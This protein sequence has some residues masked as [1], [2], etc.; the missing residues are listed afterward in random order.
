MNNNIIKLGPV[1]LDARDY[2]SQGNAILGIRDSG[3][4]YTATML[5]ERLMLAGV[6]IIAFDPIGLWRHLKSG[7]GGKEGF[8]VVVAGGEGA[9]LPLT[10]A[11]APEIVRAAMREGVSLVIDL[12][13]M[14]LSK[15]DWKRIVMSCVRVLLYENKG[16][17]LRHI[18][19]EEA[20]EFAPQRVGPDQ[21][22]VYA[23]MEKLARMGGNALLGYTL[24][25]QR[26]EEVNK[27]VLELCDG[28]FLH[29]QKG[30]NSLTALGK[31][32]DM[33][34]E[35]GGKEIIAGL[36]MLAQ[37][38]CWLWAAGTDKP[39]LIQMPAKR[40]FHPDRR[41]TRDKGAVAAK[42]S[43]TDVS[44]FVGRM[45][46]TLEKIIE[47]ARADDPKQLKAQIAKL[48]KATPTAT[49]ADLQR[50][51]ERGKSDAQATNEEAVQR[52]TVA[53]YDE[54]WADALRAVDGAVSLIEKPKSRQIDL[55][56]AL[57]PSVP[58]RGTSQNP[59]QVAFAGRTAA[60]Q[61]A[62]STGDG[63]LTPGARKL[64]EAFERQ[65]P[66]S[67]TVQ[68]AAT[69]AGQSIRSS[70]LRPNLKTL[71]DGGFLHVV[72]GGRYLSV[73]V[74]DLP[75]MSSGEILEMWA[76]KFPPA[77]ARMLREIVARGPI[78][79]PDLAAAAEISPTSSGLGSG[80]R[81]LT[82][83]GLIDKDGDLYSPSE[84]F[85]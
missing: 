25:N 72:E 76:S 10:V 28:M 5:A 78:D 81:E 36:P 75:P 38:Q 83:H 74:S 61:S 45:E 53:G 19:I 17:G 57:R 22:A 55:P 1:T 77:T 6:P 11:A 9:D 24:I 41:V 67:M 35:K 13:D 49:E 16:H 27:A 47:D 2:A 40:T 23:E 58:K 62:T 79:K 85:R 18:F 7:V 33:G 50:E 15:A 84:I 66:R 12:Y 30:R 68:Q 3:K 39:V 71:L 44:A 64:L 32:L 46:T 8:P 69:I 34:T 4:S 48:T 14:N 80:L 51:Y 26:A 42:V 54:G 65:A 59:P 70:A 60:A 82:V 52:A 31:W 56:K 63:S 29:R 73:E 20:A 43:V 37:G 21:G